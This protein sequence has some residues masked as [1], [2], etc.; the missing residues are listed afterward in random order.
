MPLAVRE[1]HIGVEQLLEMER[2]L[3]NERYVRALMNANGQFVPVSVRYRGGHTREYP[4][5]S[6]EVVRQGQTF[7]YNAEFDDPSL[8]RNALSFRF[9]EQLGVPSPRTK[10]VRLV[11]NGEPLGVYLEI[12]GVD[13]RFF[14]R[15]GIGF[16]S[17]FYAVNNNADFG[18]R[19]PE[20]NRLKPSLLAGYEH[21]AGGEEERARLASFIRGINSPDGGS[22]GMAFYRARLDVDNYLRWLAGAVLTGNYDGFEQNYALY[23]HRK[24]GKFR[25]IPWDYEG[26]WGRNCYGQSVSSR[27]V[28]VTGYNVLTAKLLEHKA[29]R[30]RY[31]DILAS[32]L[33]GP[34]TEHRIMPDAKAMM[35]SVAPYIRLDRTR[36]WSYEEFLNEASV[37]RQYIR[38]RRAI[39]SSDL[40]K[41]I[42][43]N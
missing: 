3:W 42:P 2:N 38:E 32:A 36:K 10:H 5:R 8:I 28:E 15:R 23:R 29:L 4:K 31:G 26:T 34:F 14:R 1:L 6:Y 9:L 13:R 17:L 25:I 43:S 11:L 22:K 37:I 12:E 21:K 16:T 39:V 40:R 18:L 24:S 20:T 27:L 33:K 41:M 7:H 30:R 35:A 19:N